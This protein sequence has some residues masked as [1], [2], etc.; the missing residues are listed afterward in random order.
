LSYKVR[1]ACNFPRARPIVR[2][3][4][5]SKASLTDDDFIHHPLLPEGNMKRVVVSSGVRLMPQPNSRSAVRA[6]APRIEASEVLD[7]LAMAVVVADREGAVL[8][9]NLEAVQMLG[10]GD[11]L[12]A[13]LS[14]AQ[15]DTE[16]HWRAKMGEVLSSH[17]TA[18]WSGILVADAATRLRVRC[19]PLQLSESVEPVA[20]LYVET[21][22]GED[23]LENSDVDRR[24]TSLGKVAARVAH[25]LNNPLDGILRYINLAMRVAYEVPE[26]RLNS[27]LSESR[28][29]LMRMI[30]IIG[31]LLEFSRNS[32]SAF[33]EASVNE[34]IEQAIKACSTAADTNHVVV[35]ADFQCDH[36]PTLRG[37]RF[38]QVCCNLIRNAIDAM[39][40]GGRL[41]IASGL[42][43]DCII[44]RVADTGMGLP[45][46]ADKI[47][48][49]FYTTKQPGKG[50]GLGLAICTEFITDMGGTITAANADTGGAVITVRIPLAGLRSPQ[51]VTRAS[52]AKPRL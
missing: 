27:Y 7:H 1:T 48:E 22:R 37:S 15:F 20:V 17:I 47:F 14:V 3:Q 43:E 51:R 36:M 33:E 40:D 19:A 35:S 38:Y 30:R 31:D 21:I 18:H 24:L 13:V 23:N 45:E 42:I 41:S 44:L 9:R 50:T 46:P 49:P 39:P 32:D 11:N 6:P 8:Y 10:E 5:H 25:E 52:Q 29:G 28:S 4:F 34:L 26:S 12:Q 2:A 16:C